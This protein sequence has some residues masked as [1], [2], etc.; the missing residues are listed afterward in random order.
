MKELK[1]KPQEI[2]ESTRI[3]REKVLDSLENKYGDDSAEVLENYVE[4]ILTE[5]ELDK[6]IIMQIMKEN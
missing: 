2:T 4:S 5:N 1:I 6:Q 3:A